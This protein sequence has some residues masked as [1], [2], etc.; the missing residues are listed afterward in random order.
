MKN[1]EVHMMERT[2]NGSATCHE[3]A[4]HVTSSG[5]DSYTHCGRC[6]GLMVLEHCTDLLELSGDIDFL[7]FRCLQCGDVVDP[8]ILRNRHRTPRPVQLRLHKES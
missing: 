6:S 5:S 1:M 7:A 2:M 3:P 4:P 8:V